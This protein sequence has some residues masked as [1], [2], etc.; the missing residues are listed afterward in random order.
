ME[1]IDRKKLEIVL[2]GQTPEYFEKIKKVFPSENEND[3]IEK[4]CKNVK[5][6]W[7]NNIIHVCNVDKGH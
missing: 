5:E 3:S 6:H 1:N 2:L 4:Y 7:I